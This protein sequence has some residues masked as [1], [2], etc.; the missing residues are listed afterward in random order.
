MRLS[1]EDK[2]IFRFK[3]FKNWIESILNIMFAT[4]KAYNLANDERKELLIQ[5]NEARGTLNVLNMKVIDNSQQSH[6]LN[7]R[8]QNS[9]STHIESM[10]S[11][12]KNTFV[13]STKSAKSIKNGSAKTNDFSEDF[14]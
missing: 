2:V 9:F 5:I 6:G 14:K 13:S 7:L 12:S 8:Q 11:D 1:Q 4:L 10:T 3:L